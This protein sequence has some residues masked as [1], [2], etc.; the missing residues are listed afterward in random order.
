MNKK[1]VI[2]KETGDMQKP[3]L[4][5]FYNVTKGSVDVVDR[6]KTKYCVTRISNRR[7]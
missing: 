7:P 4:I 3:E 5:T 2:D 6:M 1:G